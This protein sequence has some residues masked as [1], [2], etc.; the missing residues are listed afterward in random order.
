[1]IKKLFITILLITFVSVNFILQTTISNKRNEEELKKRILDMRD[2][3]GLIDIYSNL[4]N[5]LIPA[6]AK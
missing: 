2:T 1:M 4:F 3:N 5:E 6:N